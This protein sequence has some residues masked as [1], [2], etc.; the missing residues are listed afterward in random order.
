MIVFLVPYKDQLWR[1]PVEIKTENAIYQ[2]H[3]GS[4]PSI[5][6]KDATY[7][8]YLLFKT[9]EAAMNWTWKDGI[10]SKDLVAD[11]DCRWGGVLN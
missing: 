5:K 3:Y 1:E 4:I 11:S 10:K 2:L 6:Y 7:S 9:I 8:S